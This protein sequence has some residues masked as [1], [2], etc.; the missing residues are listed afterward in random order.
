VSPTLILTIRFAKLCFAALF[1]AGVLGTIHTDDTPGRK[2][3]AYFLAGPGF[4]GSWALGFVLTPVSGASYLAPF[5]LGGMLSSMLAL[6]VALYRAGKEGRGG[7]ASAFV[8]IAALVLTFALMSF[9]P[10]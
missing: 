8:G 5:V 6:H 10:S 3:A 9:R 7:R 4:G 2:R 1:V